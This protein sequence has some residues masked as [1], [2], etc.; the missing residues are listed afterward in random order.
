MAAPLLEL[1]GAPTAHWI[2]FPLRPPAAHALLMEHRAVAM[3]LQHATGDFD[4]DFRC[5]SVDTQMMTL[6]PAVT[7]EALGAPPSFTSKRISF[8]R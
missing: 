1:W 7:V 2:R 6:M 5:V 8:S 4:S 3:R